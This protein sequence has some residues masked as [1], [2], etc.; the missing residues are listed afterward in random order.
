MQAVAEP[1][2]LSAR[3]VLARYPA[4]R[5][6][7]LRYLE[8]WGLVRAAG[9]AR[10][11]GFRDLAVIRQTATA[12]AAGRPFRAVVRTLEAA[13]HGQLA[14]D[15]RLDAEPARVL[16]LTPRERSRPRHDTSDT[17]EPTAQDIGRAEE[18]FLAA[19]ALDNGTEEQMESAAALYRRA[20]EADPW[21]VAALINLGNIH[22]AR[23]RLAEAQALY[24]QAVQT[25]PEFFEAHYN[26]ANV[27]HDV[28]RLEEAAGA[29]TA[30]L[31]LDPGHADA[32]FYLAVTLEKV[33]RSAEA[34]PHWR[35]YQS[36]APEGAWAALARE[37]TEG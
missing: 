27:L 9:S 32:H 30:A 25:A 24:E 20:L 35:T 12:L 14:F 13:R 15:F 26:L 33:G 5:E 23:N 22:Y 2:E 1:T 19:S 3:D 16:A 34:R 17:G 6:D 21:L 11:Y 4:L 37:F 18:L 29:Y 8:K 31:E 36:I 10:A 28:G 7:H